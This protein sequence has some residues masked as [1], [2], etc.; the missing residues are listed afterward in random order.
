M[1]AFAG[2][3]TGRAAGIHFLAGA[4]RVVQGNELSVTVAVSPAGARCRA[5]VRYKGGKTQNLSSVTAAAGHASWKWTVERTTTPGR[6]RVSVSCGA[7]GRASRTFT[8]IGAVLPPTI[9]V[10]KSGWSVRTTAFGGSSVS[11][12]VILAN[13]SAQRDALDVKVL[14]NFVMSDNRLIGSASTR[15]SDIAAGTEHALGGE[16]TF[17]RGAPIARL[18]VVVVTSLTVSAV[19]LSTVVLDA[20][21]N[22]LGGGRGFEAATLPPSS[23]MF[24]KISMGL[25]PIPIAKAATALVSVVPTYRKPGT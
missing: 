18:E 1:L 4:H 5:S 21:G 11:Y 25:R 12:G 16:L 8:V 17:P 22:V 2:A 9:H 14:V 24:F 19:E 23:R 6:A 20:A 3:A 13:E 15:V 10:V 7:A